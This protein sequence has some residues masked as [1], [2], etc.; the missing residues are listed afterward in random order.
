MSDASAGVLIEFGASG[1]E[2]WCRVQGSTNNGLGRY[3][4]AVRGATNPTAFKG[5]L[6]YT[7]HP[8][9]MRAALRVHF[10]LAETVWSSQIRLFVNGAEHAGTNDGISSTVPGVFRP[11]TLRIG[12]S[13][14]GG[15][16]GNERKFAPPTMLFLP[17]GDPGLSAAHAAEID[18]RLMRSAGVLA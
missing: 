2:G 16:Y 1:T 18:K 4:A 13:P 8:A 17:S 15:G 14:S 9:P 10:D 5:S 11:G 12:G 3:G 6:P 7:S